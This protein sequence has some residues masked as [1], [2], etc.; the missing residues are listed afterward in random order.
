MKKTFITYLAFILAMSVFITLRVKAGR[1]LAADTDPKPV[2]ENLT[3]TF[4]VNAPEEE[5]EE[6]PEEPDED[7]HLWHGDTDPK[8]EFS[9][10]IPRIVCWGDSLT[11]SLDEKSAF[12]DI[13]RSLSGCEVI[14]YGVEAE[15]T[16]MIAMREGGLR[17]N[18]KATVIPADVTLIPIFLRTENNGHVHFLDN[19]D[20]G[21]NPCE[22]GGIEGELEKLNGSYYFKRSSKGE[23]T[24]IEEGT[25]F[26]T[27]AM[28]DADPEDVL[29]IFAGT[30]DLPTASSVRNIIDLERSM[31]EAAGSS[32]Y[33]IVGLT[34]AGG[35]PEI[36]EVNAALEKEFGDHFVDIRKY[37]LKYGL[38]D[39]G[40]TPTQ[41][42]IA[43]IEKGE[44]PS[45]LRMDYVHGNKHYHRLLGEQVY[46]RMKYLGY[47]P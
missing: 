16:S 32:K 11:V 13:L 31:L 44:I 5:A 18:V 36:D 10:L 7:D 6:E 24:A 34:Y 38:S 3:D 42:D 28:L 47:I 22:I 30:N 27:H 19:G 29:V 35:I 14:N 33:I 46:R 41:E 4:E 23:R 25:Q 1:V 39:S 45:S 40:I 17:V 2:S 37:M 43:D 20:G 15:N 26:M 9:G 21:V 8:S 12:P